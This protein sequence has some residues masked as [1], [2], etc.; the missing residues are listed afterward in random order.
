VSARTNEEIIRIVTKFQNFGMI[1]ELTC[2]VDSLHAALEP[3]ERDGRVVL[4]CPT[5][6]TVQERI[7]D[8]VLT[9]EELIDES[10]RRWAEAHARAARRHAR[11]D[12]WFAVATVMLACTILPFLVGG[13]LHALVIGAAG[14]LIMYVYARRAFRKVDAPDD[15]P[16]SRP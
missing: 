13:P 7:P 10:N 12:V 16:E 8:Y 15:D 6:G 9:S 2:A 14:G 11:Q 4:V 3:V 1:H 5:C